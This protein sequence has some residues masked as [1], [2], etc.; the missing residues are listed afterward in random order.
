MVCAW[1]YFAVEITLT[2]C[3]HY[4]RMHRRLIGDSMS[5]SFLNR[6]AGPKIYENTLSLLELWGNKSRLVRRRAPKRT[7]ADRMYNMLTPN[8]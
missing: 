6:V 5:P 1:F 2:I 4:R 7:A 8:Y 3:H